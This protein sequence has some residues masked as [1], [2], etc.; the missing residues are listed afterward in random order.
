MNDNPANPV[1]IVEDEMFIRM[2]AVDSLEDRGYSI[3]EAGDAQEALDLLE[4]P[5]ALRLFSRMSICPA[6]PMA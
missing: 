3:L 4:K 5:R 1:L 6:G 2:I